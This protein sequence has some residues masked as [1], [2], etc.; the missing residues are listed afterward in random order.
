MKCTIFVDI[1]LLIGVVYLFS[2]C[3]GGNRNTYSNDNNNT[4]SN[5]D[6]NYYVDTINGHIILTTVCEDRKGQVSVATIELN[7]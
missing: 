5:Y 2:M 7:N 4:Y 1:L 6:I 3:S